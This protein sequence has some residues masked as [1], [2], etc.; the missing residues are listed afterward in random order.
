MLFFFGIVSRRKIRI[1]FI[2]NLFS[3]LFDVHIEIL[4][5]SCG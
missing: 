4:E 2:Q 1:K 5:N 3:C